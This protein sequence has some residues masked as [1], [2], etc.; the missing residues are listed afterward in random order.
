MPSTPVTDE[1]RRQIRDYFYGNKEALAEVL[2]D[3]RT[4]A[5]A[6]KQ[7]GVSAKEIREIIYAVKTTYTSKH[8]NDMHYKHAADK[9]IKVPETDVCLEIFDKAVGGARFY[10]IRS[11]YRLNGEQLF[12]VGLEAQKYRLPEDYGKYMKRYFEHCLKAKLDS[13]E[14][15]LMQGAGERVMNVFLSSELTKKNFCQHASLSGST[16]E[17][18]REHA[19]KAN[20]QQSSR[21]RTRL[22]E[23]QQS[24]M[25]HLSEMMNEIYRGGTNY[26]LVDYSVKTLVRIEDL[27]RASI[28][29]GLRTDPSVQDAVKDFYDE[30]DRVGLREMNPVILAARQGGWADKYLTPQSIKTVI[31]YMRAHKIPLTP[32]HL[33]AFGKEYR[34]TNRRLPDQFFGRP[35]EGEPLVKFGNITVTVKEAVNTILRNARTQIQEQKA[36]I[37]NDSQPKR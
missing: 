14:K 2:T 12:Y 9:G 8:Y 22:K 37:I 15:E 33:D 34:R 17:T 16:F 36:K 29:P 11:Q 21:I 13:V 24:G 30:A 31:D 5:R 19:R 20:L 23:N 7:F 28:N 3:K 6:Q 1:L 25:D 27:Y 35:P 4:L 26:T 32:A 10:N 18:L